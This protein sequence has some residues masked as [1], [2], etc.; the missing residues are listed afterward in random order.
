MNLRRF[1]VG[2]AVVFSI[3]MLAIAVYAFFSFANTVIYDAKQGD[4]SDIKPYRASLTGEYIC[5]NQ[6]SEEDCLPGLLTEVNER[7]SINFMLMSQIAPPIQIG[8]TISANGS[9]TPIE[10]LSTDMWQQYDI[11]GIFS[12][13]DSVEVL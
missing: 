8:D 9:V 4:M 13:T 10:M 7:Y 6:G 12:V 5:L 1:F 11:E 3:L 2:R